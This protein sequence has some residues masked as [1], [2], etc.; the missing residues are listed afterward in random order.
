MAESALIK[1]TVGRKG[2]FSFCSFSKLKHGAVQP[3]FLT[4]LLYEYIV[5]I[6]LGTGRPVALHL[7]LEIASLISTGLQFPGIISL[8]TI[9]T[10]KK[11][12][13]SFFSLKKIDGLV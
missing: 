9:I 5:L 10:I 13:M 6:A 7:G 11:K 8:S 4:F 1:N 2:K 12:R 3:I